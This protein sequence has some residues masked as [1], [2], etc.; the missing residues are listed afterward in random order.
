M[1]K[2]SILDMSGTYPAIFAL[3]L[4]VLLLLIGYRS[5]RIS[6]ENIS[7][8]NLPIVGQLSDPGKKG[9]GGI[10]TL[11]F[12]RAPEYVRKMINH[13]KNVRHFTPPRSYK[14][15]RIF[16]NRE[17]KLPSS[18]TYYEYDV[19]PLQPGITRGTERLV[20]DQEKQLFYYTRDHY[21]TF[22]KIE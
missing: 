9:A 1:K 8:V 19:H 7:G 2:Q 18:R 3:G 6:Q 21:N 15:G 4:T 14:G 20:I 13:L 12:S 5:C 22:I 10:T 16:R 17:G 11:A